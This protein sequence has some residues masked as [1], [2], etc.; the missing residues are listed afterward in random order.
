MLSK[1]RRGRKGFT[2]IEL[3]IVVAIIGILAAIAIPQFSAYRQRAQDAQAKSMLK[4]LATALEDYYQQNSAYPAATATGDAKITLAGYATIGT[5]ATG[6]S[7]TGTHPS[8]SN[9]FTY[10]STAGGLQ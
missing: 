8:S 10:N 3:M 7:A 6:W 4:N 1:I 2:L 5:P 9:T